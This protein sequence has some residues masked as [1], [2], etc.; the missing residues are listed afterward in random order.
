MNRSNAVRES[1]PISCT[2]GLPAQT[3]GK[4]LLPRALDEIARSNPNRLYATIP[5]GIDVSQGFRDITFRE[6]ATGINF[7]AH[8]IHK[9]FG[10]SSNFEP[11]CYIGIP[12]LRSVAV[13]LAGV[14]CGYK[15]SNI[16]CK[17]SQSPLLLQPTTNLHQIFIPSPRDPVATNLSLLEQTSCS[18]ILYSK[19]VVP[20]IAQLQT[21]RHHLDSVEIH[22]FDEMLMGSTNPYPYKYTFK[23][24]VHDP[25]VVF[26]SPGYTGMKPCRKIEYG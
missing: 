24:A 14:K 18:K 22:T 23:E 13:F 12:D 26:C 2:I 1:K 20:I 3:H 9:T 15:V 8:W 5:H 4:R 19:E 21:G 25:V 7:V 10:C 16:L 11:L 6:M 17:R